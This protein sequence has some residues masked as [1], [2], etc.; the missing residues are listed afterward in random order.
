MNNVLN[1][2]G[3]TEKPHA[4]FTRLIFVNIQLNKGKLTLH[5]CKT[6]T[7]VAFT[8]HN[9]VSGHNSTH[10]TQYNVYEVHKL[11]DIWSRRCPH[12]Q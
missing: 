11:Q 5:N 12:Q 4:S 1:F 3:A 7:A 9:N 10:T 8:L 2:H 6:W